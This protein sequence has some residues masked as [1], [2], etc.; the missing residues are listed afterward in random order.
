MADFNLASKMNQFS[1]EIYF[2]RAQLYQKL[3]HYEAADADYTKVIRLSP[4]DS[5]AYLKRGNA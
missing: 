3:G 1:P 5:V 4:I 2:N